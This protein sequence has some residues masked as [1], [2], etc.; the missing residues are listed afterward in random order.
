[1]GSLLLATTQKG[2]RELISYQWQS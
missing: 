2:G 1:M